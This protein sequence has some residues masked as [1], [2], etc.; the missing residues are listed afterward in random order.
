MT[1]NGNQ[2]TVTGLPETVTIAGAEGAN[3]QL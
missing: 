3:D 2:V 1:A